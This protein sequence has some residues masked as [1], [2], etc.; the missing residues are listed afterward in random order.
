[1]PIDKDNSHCAQAT[2]KTSII[3]LVIDNHN[4]NPAMLAIQDLNNIIRYEKPQSFNIIMK[5]QPSLAILKIQI[6]YLL[7]SKSG[8][9]NTRQLLADGDLIR[10]HCNPELL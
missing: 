3:I 1:M 4:R 9:L 8:V 2:L 7:T 5:I 10:L 6:P